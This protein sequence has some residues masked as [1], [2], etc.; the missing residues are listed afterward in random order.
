MNSTPVVAINGGS[1]SIK[2]DGAL[3]NVANQ[4]LIN[5]NSGSLNTGLRADGTF[6]TSRTIRFNQDANAIEVTSGNTLTLNSAL[7]TNNRDL[8]KNDQ[9]TLILTQAQTG[10]SG[11]LVVNQG[12]L[13]INN[14]EAFGN[15]ST[16]PM[17]FYNGSPNNGNPF[18]HTLIREAGAEVGLNV[19][20]TNTIN[21]TFQIELQNNRTFGGIQSAGA[22]HNML[23]NNTIVAPVGLGISLGDQNNSVIIA[24]VDSGTSLTLGGGV[25]FGWGSGAGSI[26]LFLSADGT[27]VGTLSAPISNLTTSGTPGQATLQKVG[28]GT[29]N[30]TTANAFSPSIGL[31]TTAG[32]AIVSVPTGM[33]GLATGMV[34][35]GNPN[36]PD[37]SI[38]NGI[39]GTTIS[40]A[41]PS[42]F[43]SANVTA[44]TNVSSRIGNSTTSV[45]VLGIREGTL[46]INGAGALS[47][48]GLVILQP[49]ATLS[50]DNSGTNVDNRLGGRPLQVYGGSFNLNGNAAVATT[51]QIGNLTLSRGN[52][53]FTI[54][55]NAAQATSLVLG[56][57]AVR[58]GTTTALFRGTGLGNAAGAG[59]AVVT[60]A[61][62][63][64]GFTFIGQSGATGLA[65]KAILPWALVDNTVGGV[66]ISFATADSTGSGSSGINVL[67]PLSASEYATTLTTAANVKLGV[68]ESLNLAGRS[69]NSLTLSSGGGLTI[70]NP[71]ALSV[72]SGGIL[73]L[74]GNA[75]IQGGLLTTGSGRELII[76]TLGDTTI[77]S[78]ITGV[79]GGLTKSGAGTLTLTDRQAYLGTTAINQ[80]ILKLPSGSINP[81]YFNN[82]L[83]VSKEGTLDLNG[84]VQ[85]VSGADA[86]AYSSVNG[87]GGQIINTGATQ[88]TLVSGT[89]GTTWG[90]QI[91]GNI[92]VA[93]GSSWAVQSSQSYTGPTAIL[94]GI[95][96]LYD[97]GA[98][99]NTSAI[100][101]NSALLSLD[102]SLNVGIDMANRVNDAAPINMTGGGIQLVGR[103]GMNS[104][105][106]LGA[107]TISQ[108]QSALWSANAGV[109]VNSAELTIASLTQVA[110]SHGTMFF[111]NI[112]GTIGSTSRL[113]ITAAPTL[114]NH[115]LANAAG[116]TGWAVMNREFASYTAGTGIGALN[117][118]GYA[119]YLPNTSNI[120]NIGDATSNVRV[121]LSAI[122]ATATDGTNL[123]TVPNTALFQVGQAIEGIGIAPG[124]TVSQI[125]NGTQ[126]ILSQSVTDA[127][128]IITAKQTLSGN[129]TM[130]TLNLDTSRGATLDLGGNTLTLAGG[131]LIASQTG[132]NSSSVTVLS[133]S[134]TSNQVVIREVTAGFQVGVSLLDRTVTAISAPAEDGSVTVTVSSNPA[135]DRAFTTP[136]NWGFTT[137][138]PSLLTVTNGNLT[139]GTTSS[140]AD[141]YIHSL[142]NSGDADTRS[143]MLLLGANVVDNSAGGAVSLVLSGNLS[144]TTGNGIPINGILNGGIISGNNTYSGGT[145]VNSGT[146]TL[147]NP[148]ANGTSIYSVPGD[149]TITGGYDPY[150]STALRSTVRMDSANQIKH[151][152]TLTLNGNAQFDMNDFAQTLAGININN[153]G[154]LTA[155]TIDFGAATLTVNGNVNATSSSPG[156]VTTLTSG[157]I[158]FNGT[159]TANSPVV[160]LTSG[161]TANLL[162]GAQVSG[163]G[164]PGGATISAIVD[165]NTFVISANATSTA[166]P[167]M[168]FANVGRLSLGGA[169]RTYNIQPA[170]VNGVNVAP[171]Q[172]TLNITAPIIDG[173]ASSGINKTG[174]GLLQLGGQSLF[175]GGVN[176][177]AGGLVLSASSIGNAPGAEITSGPLGT[178]TLTLADDSVLVSTTAV[179]LGNTVVSNGDLRFDGLNNIT[180]N[181]ATSLAAA[182]TITVNYPAQTAT[183]GGQIGGAHA[184][185]K[186]GQGTLV[187]STSYLP[188][189]S[190]NNNTM[191]GS[192]TVNNGILRLQGA[193]GAAAVTPLGTTGITLNG[194]MLDL[195]S[196]GASS[197]GTIIFGNN[198]TVAP[199]QSSAIIN[200]DRVSANTANTIQMG[201]LTMSAG[202]TLNVTSSNLYNLLFTGG[203]Y[204]GTGTI[205][206]NPAANSTLTIGG[207]FTDA[208][209]YANTGSGTLIV[210]GNNF[211]TGGTEIN[212]NTWGAAPVVNT[213]TTP[214]GTGTVTLN[215]GANFA[216]L[217]IGGMPQQGSPPS[218]YVAGGLTAEYFSGGA[219]NL[220]SMFGSGMA[221]GAVSTGVIPGD[222][223]L[224]NRPAVVTATAG[225]QIVYSG[226][227]NITNG[228]NYTFQIAAGDQAQLVIDGVPV[229]GFNV[230]TTASPSADTGAALR[231]DG[232]GSITLTPGYHSITFKTNNLVGGGGNQL[233]Y[234]GPDTAG[235]GLP[236]GLNGVTAPAENLQAIPSSA[237]YWTSANATAANNYNSAAQINNAFVIPAAANVTLDGRGTDI[238]SSVASLN[239]GAGSTLN[240]SNQLGTGWIGVTGTTTVA[241]AGVTV[242]PNGGTLNLIGGINDGGNGLAK[243]GN[244]TLILGGSTSFTGNL[245]A[246]AGFV[247][248]SASNALPTGTTTITRGT[249][250]NIVSV[251]GDTVSNT[252][253]SNNISSANVKVGM[254]VTGT[255]IPANAFVTAVSGSTITLNTNAT[256]SGTAADLSFSQATLNYIGST[257]NNSQTVTITGATTSLAPG[258]YVTGANIQPGTYITAVNANNI[259]LSQLTVNGGAASNTTLTI[260]TDTYAA[261][262]L[263]GTSGVTGNITLNG[264]SPILR[265]SVTPATLYNSSGT[266]ASV[267]GNI[268]IGTLGAAIGGYGTISLNGTITDSGTGFAKVGPGTLVLGGNN[269]GFTGA[270]AVQNGILKLANAGG[271]GAAG[272]RALSANTTNGSTTVT[273]ESTTGLFVGQPVTGAGIP[274]NATIASITSPT[275]FTLSSSATASQ[276]GAS[277]T[278]TS[279]VSISSTATLDMAGISTA[280]GGKSLYLNGAGITAAT[281]LSG[282]NYLA[283]LTNTSASAVTVG[284]DIVLRSASSIG[285][286]NGGI[287][288]AGVISGSG[289]ALTK[290]GT[291][292]V[293][294]TNTNTYTG[295]TTVSNGSLTVSGAAGRLG[296]GGTVTVGAGAVLNL[297]NGTLFANRLNTRPLTLT[298]GTLNLIGNDTATTSETISGGSLTFGNGAS[299][300]NLQPGSGQAAQILLSGSGNTVARAGTGTGLISGPGLGGAIGAA[301]TS[302]V[303]FATTAPASIGQTGAAG[304]ANR[305]IIPWLLLN[306]TTSGTTTFAAFTAV[307]AGNAGLVQLGTADMAA[308]NATTANHNWLLNSSVTAAA[309]TTL[310]NSLTL[311]T[312]AALAINGG[313]TVFLD[314]G[315]IL[316]RGDSSIVGTSAGGVLAPANTF[317]REFI[318][319]VLS[320][321]TL[322]VGSAAN[323]LRIYSVNGT[324]LTKAG[325]GTLSLNS[326]STYLGN[327]TVNGGTL[328]FGAA[329]QVINNGVFTTFT[330]APAVGSLGSSPSG[331]SLVVN[332][333]GVVDLN[334]SLQSFANLTSA[335]TL[336]GTGGSI[337]NS[338]AA[339]ATLRIGTSTNGTWA[340]NISSGTGMLNLIKDGGSTWLVTSANTMTGSVTLQGGQTQLV[341][342]GAFNNA[343]SLTIRRAALVWNDNGIDAATR[344]GAS[345]PVT[346]N[347]G[348]FV[349]QARAGTNG[350]ISIGNLALSGGSSI[351]TATPT[352]GTA[353]INI[354]SLASRATGATLTF[355]GGGGPAGNGAI[356]FNTAPTL[357]NGILGGWAVALG[358]DTLA[359]GGTNAEFATYDP[360][361]GIRQNSS[362][363][364]TF[365][366]G[367]SLPAGTVLQ[368]TN[369]KIGPVGGGGTSTIGLG[370][371][372]VNSLTMGSGSTL[373]FSLPD[374]VLT[375][376]SGGILAGLDN[377]TRTL[378]NLA[379]AAGRI[380]AGTGQQE[381]FLHV[382]GGTLLVNSAIIDNGAP[383]NVVIDGLSQTANNPTVTVQ[384]L[385]TY[386]GTTYVNGAIVNL[387]TTGANAING[388]LIISGGTNGTDSMPIANATVSLLQANQIADS[389]A[390]T[391]NGGARLQMNRFNDTI[392]SLTFNNDGGSNGNTAPSVDSLGGILTV[393]GAITATAPQNSIS[394]PVLNGFLDVTAGQTFDIAANSYI[395]GQ[396]GLAVNAALIGSG[397]ITKT[398]AGVLGFGGQSPYSGVLTVNQGGLAF[399]SNSANLAN[400]AVVLS[401][402]TTLDTRGL[403]GV[404][405]SLAGSGTVL[406]Y[407]LNT[408]GTL[409]TGYDNTDTTFSGVFQSPFTQ[410]RLNVEK[411]G[412]GTWTLGGDSSTAA[413]N[414]TSGT[415]TVN[416]GDVLLNDSDARINFTTYNLNSTGGLT[417]DNS[418][419][420]LSNR[421]GGATYS[422]ISTNSANRVMNISG[423]EFSLTGGAGAVTE[424]ITTLN[425]TNG[426]GYITMTPG[427][428]STVFNVG[429]L[430]AAGSNGGTLVIRGAG[431]GG[432]V[433]SGSVNVVA[434]TPNLIGGN[435]AAGSTTMSI[436]PDILGDLS[437]TGLG[438]GFVTHVAGTG[439]RLLT[440]AEM[441]TPSVNTYLGNA[442]PLALQG[443]TTDNVAAA[444]NV[445]LT[446]SKNLYL[447]TTVNSLTLAGG[448][449]YLA[450]GGVAVTASPGGTLYGANGQLLTLTNSSGGLLGLASNVGVGGGV[451]ASGGNAAV[452]HAVGDLNVR[453]YLTS[454]AGIVKS[455]PGTVVWTR[456]SLSTSATTINN[457][458]L[459]LA[460]GN[461]SLTLQQTTI[462]GAVT[463]D[464]RVNGG[465]LDLNGTTQIGGLLLNNNPLPGTGGTI[466]SAA[467]AIFVNNS[468]ADAS[469]R[470][471]GGSLSGNVSFYKTGSNASGITTFSSALTHTGST[472]VLAGG[473]TL[474]DNGAI[475]NSSAVNVKFATLTLD[476]QGLAGSSARIGSSIP[477]NLSGASFVVNGRQS[478][479]TQQL[480]PVSLE[481]GVSA[482]TINELGSAATGGYTLQLANLSRNAAGGGVVNFTTGGGLTL[483]GPASGTSAQGSQPLI[484]L[485]QVN[486]SS[487]TAAN[488]VNNIIGGWAVVN[489]SEFATYRD[490]RGVSYLSNAG[491]PG[492]NGTDL[493]AAG[494]QATWNIND[495]S[496]RTLT[497]SKTVNSIRNAPGGGQTITLGTGTNPITLTIASGGLITNANQA[498][499]YTPGVAGSALTSGSP[500]LYVWVNQNTTTINSKINGSI[501]LVKSGPG[502]LNLNAQVNLSA[503]TTSGSSTITVSSTNGLA[504][505]QSVSGTNIPAGSTIASIVSP[506]Q[507]T[508]S[509]NATA[510]GGVTATVNLPATGVQWQ[511]NNTAATTTS[512]PVVAL[513]DTTGLTIGMPIAG[514][515]IPP[516][517]TISSID[518][519]TQI[520]LSQNATANATGVTVSFNTGSTFANSN[521]YT[522]TTIINQGTVN[523]NSPSAGLVLIPGDIVINGATSSPGILTENLRGGQIASGVNVTINGNGTFNAFV[524][525]RT[526]SSLSLNATGGTAAPA[527]NFNTLSQTGVTVPNSGNTYTVAST[528]GLF[529]GQYVGGSGNIPV[530]TKIT[531]I[532][533]ATKTVTISNALTGSGAAT[534]QTLNYFGGG[535]INLT[536]AN[537]LN[538]ISDNV[539]TPPVISGGTLQ[540]SNAAP[541]INVSGIAPVGLI[542]NSVITSAGGNVTK[543][544]N[545]SI[546]IGGS[547][548]FNTGFT[549]N[550]G[551]VILSSPSNG[552]ISGPLGTGALTVN[553]GTLMGAASST[554]SSTTVN[555]SP[556]MTVSG[557]TSLLV[558][559]MTV[560]GTNVQ[561]GSTILEIIS[562]TQIKLS[563]NATGNGTNNMTY[564][565]ATLA[566]SNAV[567]LNGDLT[568]GG[569]TAA[570]SLR[571]DGVFTLAAGQRSISVL[572]PQV[573]ATLA[574]QV[575]GPGGLTKAGNG[576]LILSN[577]ST[578]NL[579]NYSGPTQVLGGLLKMGVANALPATTALTVGPGATLDLAGRALTVGSLTGPTATTG[580]MITNS[581]G[582]AT[583]TV[584]DT[585]ST[586]YAGLI[587]NSTSPLALTKVGSGTLTLPG[588]NTYTGITTINNGV[589]SIG[590]MSS[591][592]RAGGIGIAAASATNL[593]I[594]NGTLRYTG[595]ATS[596]DKSFTIQGATASSATIDASGTGAL[597]MTAGG[598]SYGT[599][600]LSRNLILTGSSPS[601]VVNLF[602]P[603]LANNGT[604]VN[605]LT[606]NG[607]NTWA[608]SGTHSYTGTTSVNEGTLLLRRMNVAGTTA[609]GSLNNTAITVANGATLG[610]LMGTGTNNSYTAGLVS[611]ATAGSTLN[612]L[613]GS[614][615][616]LTGDGVTGNFNLQ[617]GSSV[618]TGMTIA[619]SPGSITRLGFDIGGTTT[620]TDKIVVSRGVNVTSSPVRIAI[621]ALTGTT[622]ITPGTYDLIT[623][624]TALT[625]ASNFQLAND[626]I[627]LSPTVAYNLVLGSTAAK[628]FLTVSAATI[629]N[630]Y[631]DGSS[632]NLWNNTANW[633]GELAGTTTPGAIPDAVD[634]V[635]FTITGGGANLSTDLGQN[636]RVGSLNFNSASTSAVT[637]GGT[638]SLTINGSLNSDAGSAAH[639]INAPVT[640]GSSQRWTIN[641]S[642]LTVNGVISDNSNLFG[643]TKAGTGELVLTGANTFSGNTVVE[644]GVLSVSNIQNGGV[645]SGVGMSSASASSILLSGGT[646]RYTG[647][648]TTTD[649]LFSVAIAGGTLDASGSGAL[650]FNN[651]G[652]IGQPD[653]PERAGDRIEGSADINNLTS[654]AD[655]VVGMSVSGEGIPPGT[656]ITAINSA[657]SITLSAPAALASSEAVA[658]G[659]PRTLT[660]AG[661]NMGDNTLSP[662][663]TGALDLVKTGPGNWILAG[664][665][666]YVGSTSIEQGSLTVSS[667]NSTSSPL[668]SSSLGVPA[669]A[670]EAIISLGSGSLTG[671][672]IYTGLGETTDRAFSL[673]GTT[674][675][676][677]IKSSGT[678]GLVIT[679][680]LIAAGAGAK[681]FE[682][683]GSNTGYNAFQ[684]I[685]S[686]N[687]SVN[688]TSLLKTGAGTWYIEA[689][690]TYTGSTNIQDGT[691]VASSL[692]RVSGGTASSSLGAPT[693]ISTGTI[694]LGSGTTTGTLRYVGPGESTDRVIN[695]AGTTGGGIIDSSGS[696]ALVFESGVTATGAGAKTLTLTGSNTAVN[697]INGVIGD[698][699]ALNPTSLVKAGDGTWLLAGVNTYTGSTTINGGQLQVGIA[700]VGRT[701]SGPLT[702]NAGTLS[703]SGLVNGT[704]SVTN[705]VLGAGGTLQPGDNGGTNIGNLSFNG[706]LAISDGSNLIFQISSATARDTNVLPN[707]AAGTY[708]SLGGYRDNLTT[709]ANWN[710]APVPLAAHDTISVAGEVFF[711]QGTFTVV[712]NGYISSLTARL[713]LPGGTTNVVGDYFDLGDWLAINSGSSFDAGSNYRTGG[714]GGGG[715]VLPELPGGLVYDVS[716]F[717]EHGIIGV[718]VTPPAI[719]VRINSYALAGSGSWSLSTNWRPSTVPGTVAG[720]ANLTSNI[721][722]NAIVTLDGNRTN[723]KI[724]I[725]DQSNSNFFTIARGTSGSLIFDNGA[726]GNALLSKTQSNST[727]VAVDVIAAPVQLTSGLNINVNTGTTARMDISGAISSTTP[728]SLVGVTVMGAGRVNFTGTTANTY[729]GDTRVIN[730]GFGDATNP[731]L[732]L[733]KSQSNYTDSASFSTTSGSNL[734]TVTGDRTTEIN[735]GMRI[736]GISAV[737]T[738]SYISNVKYN[739]TLNRTEITLTSNATATTT[740]TGTYGSFGAIDLKTTSGSNVATVST[741]GNFTNLFT[742]GAPLA[743]NTNLPAGVTITSVTYNPL[744]NTTTLGLSAAATG[745]NTASTRY[746]TFAK[747]TSGSNIVDVSSTAGFY[748]GMPLTG[749]SNIPAGATVVSVTS[750]TRFT[751]SVAATGTDTAANTIFGSNVANG[752]IA[753]N[754]II[755]NMSLGGTG[756]AIVHQGGS[757]QIADTALVR[758][759]AGN[760]FASTGN[761][762]NNAYWKLM[763]YDETVRGISDFTASG[764]IENTEGESIAYSSTLTL[765]T[766]GPQTSFNGFLRNR[767]NNNG[768]GI[769]NLAVTGTGNQELALGN[770]NYTGS[771]TISSGAR[772]TLRNTT[773]FGSSVINNGTLG[774]RSD[775]T[776]VNFNKI[777]T[778]TGNVVRDGG[779]GTI[780]LGIPNQAA[781]VTSGSNVVTVGTTAGLTVG[782]PV[783]G[784]GIAAGATIAS[785]LNGTQYTLS[786]NATAT[787][788][789]TAT[790][791]GLLQIGGATMDTASKI[792]TLASTTGLSVGMA[793]SGPGIQ[794][795]TVITSINSGTH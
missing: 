691:L 461:N 140:P 26:N 334:G 641:S 149:I 660:L 180:L 769:L 646:L 617:Q 239:L 438:M 188:S 15:S 693:T 768:T 604:A 453:S 689:A 595:A 375:V 345:T 501:G 492:Y 523:L 292:T 468:A 267:A 443:T 584:G 88:A 634:N 708:D 36:I 298:G 494:T 55:P 591:S 702:V 41:F 177:A 395:P 236:V 588:V 776:N 377:N 565:P 773:N 325:N 192:M 182:S 161:S 599:T 667:I 17:G 279:G 216:I 496:S 628:E 636:I 35:N 626:V 420:I 480:G 655:L 274:A 291:N 336:P 116:Q 715:L 440:T 107:V 58:G 522:G 132:D 339:P 563:A 761:N 766:S 576:T 38:I 578:V 404:I 171:L 123:V 778:G 513:A 723:G 687:S 1:I 559:G 695:L 497:T 477:L 538:A 338:A 389:S 393:T 372:T 672:L 70:G 50:L 256:V 504:I 427:T 118:A 475:L 556:Y 459:V 324:G 764:V 359:V 169:T 611:T 772:L 101:I 610:V 27:G 289:T 714:S 361:A 782:M 795:G 115:L 31:T 330:T 699:S 122:T 220:N 765:A 293:T 185:T 754:L 280:A 569:T 63:A 520:T 613:A 199:A 736:S 194:G 204:S 583:L 701:G 268:N 5:T 721:T 428:G 533:V 445:R 157:N 113:F 388:N 683:G 352:N 587:T 283:S 466:T 673:T 52:T 539:A 682:L 290:T 503:T 659:T 189:G 751:M 83:Y 365:A 450:T 651:T 508:I 86:S 326:P 186:D 150:N 575:T 43:T 255:G 379:V 452:L 616:N 333:G 444:D 486:G 160:K 178:G 313:S 316:A 506:T 253:T 299:V 606:K 512:S 609:T 223:S 552:A 537:A 282:A 752:A 725:G 67:R 96:T 225:T 261:L 679:S 771:T 573:T 222:L 166:A 228:G 172:A 198:V 728:G 112:G 270:L 442:L 57:L 787:I 343:S 437:P 266:A 10:N 536:A 158:A 511:S 700:G 156:N 51:E 713:A 394:I 624:G 607:T 746:G 666:T 331:Q 585:T 233:L 238:N 627:V 231:G 329:G 25:R 579:N 495:G 698:N 490:D 19:A 451:I 272:S 727:T 360:V 724:I 217:P 170:L 77:G 174:A 788:G 232:T 448:G 712:D 421:L 8:Y 718:V 400:A 577:P 498:I 243:T 390:V 48:T 614:T 413:G 207:G 125:T 205:N 214:F 410:G 463:P 654:T 89:S 737:P 738:T 581:S 474:R 670:T 130:N 493:S 30:I 458:R 92:A 546:M 514:A 342:S 312:G 13:Q 54:N 487:F 436:R 540:L 505:G 608:I 68:V 733:A 762:G 59:T 744:N 143:R 785:I 465:T 460:G 197:E 741:S 9:G 586:T 108:G 340:G 304:S 470:V 774:L 276:T 74:A 457:G 779:S 414:G 403:T 571:L 760:G 213:I 18:H 42:G 635:Y 547:N 426:T 550:E 758:F 287:T 734:V 481:Q 307:G 661:T 748:P 259:V 399:T 73:A 44:G 4:V 423:G 109:G 593:V 56:G 202:Q 364:T 688:T 554:I 133:S 541:V 553:G 396:V 124:T 281:G 425:I 467:P 99:L 793:V 439:F 697:R 355:S 618:T 382:G 534:N 483:G 244:G 201:T 45:N 549:L 193:A 230:D 640:L 684:G 649:R 435:G 431:L 757:N 638:S 250:P 317:N 105:E 286:Y 409:R 658:F 542:V 351:I 621:N 247:Q 582:S 590:V 175:S 28:S 397:A 677:Y 176:V 117:T 72:E 685:I 60:G 310:S 260:S 710:A 783:S 151:T 249:L 580:G 502:S 589:I 740:S 753:G 422:D 408:A 794:S 252:N 128:P 11:A 597:T 509:Q 191:S 704:A 2:N 362:Y 75:G 544:G 144:R 730:R 739:P 119:G 350:A 478:F 47:G 273:V 648:G 598:L 295:G 489:G 601:G 246:T 376:N 82:F 315:G 574:G 529:V 66:G 747:T 226:L 71:Y 190:L 720:I 676:G 716:Q 415:L 669:N 49:N 612:L 40:L 12:R 16:V 179:I 147:A 62:T 254:R 218:G 570:N 756:T 735:S 479:D 323:P 335:G 792:V 102:N 301:N 221:P 303:N 64:A 780:T 80:G 527:I 433:G 711:G 93:R 759:D 622:N 139:S 374:D 749:N 562:P 277:L 790:Y 391:I 755:G 97:D 518:S 531:D 164:I 302:T 385:N 37:G 401:S 524:G 356:R 709:L 767:A 471:F 142:P 81:I 87:T 434:T 600:N 22:I 322:D 742:T 694:G 370:G 153:T 515:G 517:T 722:S 321:A 429:T 306:D 717:A 378:G 680:N 332:N 519:A 203:S 476:N 619:S 308:A 629:N 165:A 789:T 446:Q 366:N 200:V 212:G 594:S 602:A 603:V 368:N 784:T 159:T 568:F 288:L 357:T 770:I 456:G 652:V 309:G 271:L 786:A 227:I 275:T 242:N 46:G 234:G 719:P 381:L 296:A 196:N 373:L 543:T 675:G 558:P 354:N 663:L 406:N 127:N 791:N 29:W 557:G 631:W 696:G 500:D 363:I 209:K 473:V 499:A 211:F 103:H 671:G 24:G 703:G 32:S 152:G 548:T 383:L 469:N 419:A 344:L 418:A 432:A 454:T 94:G 21:E 131:G 248:L 488:M 210:G 206:F 100:Q 447:N 731:Q 33:T 681:T 311:D 110:G 387:N 407:N 763:G 265:N 184:I 84:S 455:G 551:T 668:P 732:V 294:I 134:T 224:N 430:A 516:G 662:A 126:M 411:I 647:T 561:A 643:L 219:S 528:D 726:Y 327:T 173:G 567:A 656:T 665:N 215:N 560:T 241:G 620:A 145:F 320:G 564:A 146:W 136:T 491:F 750:A 305:A 114:S 650:V 263:N 592:T 686:D 630:L 257:G 237:L 262:D 69:I 664:E 349:Y 235:N 106:T 424:A 318:V 412:T 367:A 285:G 653:V 398:G 639:V 162:V 530:G 20:G 148:L 208:L 341:D 380:T 240:V 314:S 464:V 525:P 384:G 416:G 535:S 596:T 78:T 623:S 392:A 337:I 90:G 485:S 358:V 405:G 91:S 566:L 521:T 729:L 300:I 163:T 346:L 23:G 644:A 781:N 245:T 195:R 135:L 155:P 417:L 743:L 129:R 168:T 121:T 138:T 85:F 39:S 555:T 141:L 678:G 65:N 402:G 632:S 507:F 79:N 297:D 120:V 14:L 229:A 347:S 3:G 319:H 187:F 705:H 526:L 637:I 775:G 264:V 462:A 657:T 353:L 269:T 482:I 167:S 7:V 484:Y 777:V 472:N 348:A 692:N 645:A 95:T 386:T 137:L 707:L 615:F 674:G 104:T 154:G 706:N 605:S 53:V 61:S 6:S 183:F 572:N 76:H 449:G 369:V 745:S 111:R 251:S 633:S 532:N 98:L 545:G 642:L 258:M 510:S 181:G 34:I 278:A 284:N 441:K 625:G 328:R 371:A 690:N